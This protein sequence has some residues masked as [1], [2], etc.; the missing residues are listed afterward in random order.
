MGILLIILGIFIWYIWAV[1]YNK[2][3]QNPMY[4]KKIHEVP[5]GCLPWV[6]AFAIIGLGIY[7]LVK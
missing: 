1:D 5:L 6:L 7:L 4:Y 3:Q 2:G